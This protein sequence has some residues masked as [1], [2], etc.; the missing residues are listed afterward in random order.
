MLMGVA[1]PL[2]MLGQNPEDWAVTVA[3]VNRAQ[4]LWAER[5]G[6][7]IK[8]L[9]ESIGGIVANKVGRLLIETLRA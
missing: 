3:V 7:E 6:A 4:Q 8:A 2:A 1:D 5:R 9:S